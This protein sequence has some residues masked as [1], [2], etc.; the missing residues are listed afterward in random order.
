[1]KTLRRA[2]VFLAALILL[3]V[4]GFVLWG[5]FPTK[6]MPEALAAL[7][8][9][10]TVEVVSDEWFYFAPPGDNP[11][12]GLILYPGG[13]VD[14]RAYAPAAHAIASYGYQVFITP[15]PLNLAVFAPERAASVIES[16]PNVD[17]WVIGGHSLGG[18]MAARFAHQNPEAIDGL[19][20]WASYPPKSSDLSNADLLVASIYGT[21]DGLTSPEE[22]LASAQFLPKQTQFIA[23]EGGNHA[24]F[25]WYGLQGG[26]LE[27]SLSR[28][29][30]QSIVV[31]A[32]I[33]LL[34]DVAVAD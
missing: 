26:D 8:S 27:A 21:R 22:I 28:L 3:T 9:D 24:Q 7:K 5:S 17:R 32:T 34:H 16:F 20:L 29:D 6:P 11:T 18:A 25:G 15:M 10:A 2:L 1:M 33:D 30:Q 23:V 31:D 13:R 4:V 12:V 19:L 14:P